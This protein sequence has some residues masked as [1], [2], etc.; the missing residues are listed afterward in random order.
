MP[1]SLASSSAASMHGAMVPIGQIVV[2]GTSTFTIT[3]SSIPQVYRDLKLIGSARTSFNNLSES[4]GLYFNNDT[5][6]LYSNTSLVTADTTYPGRNTNVNQSTFCQVISNT[7]PTGDFNVVE[8][9]FLSYSNTSTNKSA[10]SKHAADYNNSGSGAVGMYAILWR[11][12]N[13]I[14]SISIQSSN[15]AYFIA[16]TTFTLYGIRTVGQ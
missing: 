14:T 6:S 16:G 1:V 15:G 2:S 13:A 12:T 11:N 4:L 3:F 8:T 10:I 7:A 5:S 9:D